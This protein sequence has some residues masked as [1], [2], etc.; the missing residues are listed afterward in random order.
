MVKF[1]KS[2]L[3]CA[4]NDHVDC[5]CKINHSIL[6]I[7]LSMIFDENGKSYISKNKKVLNKNISEK[8][9]NYSIQI[10]GKNLVKAWRSGALQRDIKDFLTNTSNNNIDRINGLISNEFPK[11]KSIVNYISV[12]LKPGTKNKL[13]LITNS[14]K[15]GTYSFTVSSRYH[16][17]TTTQYKDHIVSE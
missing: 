6:E 4:N 17:S 10:D 2:G 13:I 12:T 1:Y 3:D 9:L 5:L 11:E 8:D 14:N 15:V 16:T 7:D